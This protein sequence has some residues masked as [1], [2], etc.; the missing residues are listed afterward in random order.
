MMSQLI[1]PVYY[2]N[3]ILCQQTAE[4]NELSNNWR[5]KCAFGFHKQD[6]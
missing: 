5:Q 6:K 1:V 2:S 4:L 3:T